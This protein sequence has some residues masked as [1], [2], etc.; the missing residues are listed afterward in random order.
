MTHDV[1]I[2]PYEET[3]M[4]YYCADVPENTILGILTSVFGTLGGIIKCKKEVLQ[5]CKG[6]PNDFWGWGVEDK[7]L[8]NRCEYAGYDI[9]LN[10]LNRDPDRKTHFHIFD[11][12]DDRVHTNNYGLK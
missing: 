7:A 1:D 10:I 12:I 4:Q 11:D 6:F 2:N 5:D 3:I 9:Q 8:K